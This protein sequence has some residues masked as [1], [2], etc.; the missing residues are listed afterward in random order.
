MPQA[1]PDLVK[2]L[3]ARFGADGKGHAYL[4]L[5]CERYLKDQGYRED[6]FQWHPKPGVKTLD[7]MTQE[8]Y[9]CLLYLITEWD[10]GGLIGEEA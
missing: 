4:D 9:D 1:H 3:E 7:D 10:W 6:R 8:E 2:R 5:A